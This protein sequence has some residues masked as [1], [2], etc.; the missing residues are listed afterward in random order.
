M[1]YDILSAHWK[2]NPM[3]SHI[4]SYIVMNQ[5]NPMYDVIKTN[6][7]D[8]HSF[9]NLLEVSNKEDYHTNMHFNG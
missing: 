9:V 2:T 1:E 3:T 8:M 7:I 5:Y 4:S 6:A